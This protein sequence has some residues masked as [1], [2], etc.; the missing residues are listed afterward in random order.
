MT[1]EK[2][3]ANLQKI[4]ARQKRY[5]A[6]GLCTC[7]GP[8]VPGYTDCASC[9]QTRQA[10]N[11]RY[12]AEGRCHCGRPVMLGLKKNGNPFKTCQKCIKRERERKRR[13]HSSNINKDE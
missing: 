10:R 6:M 1:E 12:R 3:L 11:Q 13:L 5:K 4:K 2:R 8:P 9:R 7:G